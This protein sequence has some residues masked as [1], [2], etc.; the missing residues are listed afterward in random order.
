[1]KARSCSL[2]PERYGELFSSLYPALWSGLDKS[3]GLSL[4]CST[5]ADSG[6]VRTSAAR[7][8]AMGMPRMSGQKHWE[9]VSQAPRGGTAWKGKE[10]ESHAV[11][12]PGDEGVAGGSSCLQGPGFGRRK[13]QKQLKPR[14]YLGL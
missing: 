11:D 2:L 7:V 9:G 14:R 13:S 10:E 4:A 1:M 8:E 12:R 3:S 6:H 5:C